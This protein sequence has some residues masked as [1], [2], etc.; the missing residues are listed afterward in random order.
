MIRYD[1]QTETPR[2]CFIFY[3]MLLIFLHRNSLNGSV[4]LI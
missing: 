1:F 4:N 3:I 2:T